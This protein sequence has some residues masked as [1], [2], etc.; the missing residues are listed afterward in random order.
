MMLSVLFTAVLN[1]SSIPLDTCPA[2]DP[3]ARGI[4][5]RF[6]TSE[7]FVAERQELGIGDLPRDSLLLLTDAA[8]GNACRTI[9]EQLVLEDQSYPRAAT[10]YRMGSRYLIVTTTQ[11]PPDRLYPGWQ[12]LIVLDESLRPIHGFAM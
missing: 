10:Y 11:V 2:E 8:D 12:Q 4:A 3:S 6:M 5:E 1:A 9:N 7:S